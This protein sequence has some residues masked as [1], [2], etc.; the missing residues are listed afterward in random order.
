M[1]TVMRMAF[2]SMLVLRNRNAC[3]GS[4][5]DVQWRAVA[6]INFYR[7]P[8]RENWQ[9]CW[10]KVLEFL[11]AINNLPIHNCKYRFEIFNLHVRH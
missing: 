5:A 8:F 3:A 2:D 1:E 10:T 7:R 9:C 6:A 4:F 11:S